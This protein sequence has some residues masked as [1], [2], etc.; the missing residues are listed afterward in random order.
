MGDFSDLLP[1]FKNE[2]KTMGE[3]DG[4]VR[5]TDRDLITG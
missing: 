5:L 4:Y 1:A 2:N 3:C